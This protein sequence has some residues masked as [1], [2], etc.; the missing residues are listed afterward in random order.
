MT[1]DRVVVVTGAGRGIG[2]AIAAR[3]ADDGAT[4]IAADVDPP[5]GG[6]PRIDY[7]HVDVSSAGEA[8]A[9]FAGVLATHGRVDV[10]VNNAGIWF[11]RRFVEI[12][13]DEWDRVLAVN[14]RGV[15]L[16]TKAA[17]DPMVATGGGAIINIGSQAGLTVTR[18]QGAHYHA[19]KAAIAHLTKVVA[20]ELG[21]MGIRVNCVA[22]G[23]TLSDPSLLPPEL[24][25]QIPLGRAGVPADLVGACVF[26]ASPDASYITGQTLVV[27]GGAVALL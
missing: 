11:R 9:L 1:S 15:F 26:L 6:D 27:N 20:F 3:F 7:R 13:V 2:A 18:G 4:V 12:S 8:A 10:L 22:P 14:L 24:R 25:S 21:P 5:V 23:A 19:S 16:C 17:V